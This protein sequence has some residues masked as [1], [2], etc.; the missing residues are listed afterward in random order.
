[1]GRAAPGVRA[2]CGYRVTARRQQCSAASHREPDRRGVL[3]P[4]WLVRFA[5]EHTPTAVSLDAVSSAIVKQA[6]LAGG[7]NIGFVESPLV[8][9]ELARAVME[10]LTASAV[11]SAV[12]DEA[13]PAVLSTM[14]VQDH[15][16]A[17]RGGR[18]RDRGVPPPI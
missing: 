5:A 16:P 3:V 6:A 1:M 15:L 18:N 12:A 10:I 9:A 17:R 7:G 2:G 13:G 11:R 4:R 8:A 14:A